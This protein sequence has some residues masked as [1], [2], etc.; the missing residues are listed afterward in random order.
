MATDLLHLPHSCF[1]TRKLPRHSTPRALHGSVMKSKI[2]CSASTQNSQLTTEENRISANYQPNMWNYDLLQSSTSDRQIP[3]FL[4]LCFSHLSVNESSSSS[5]ISFAQALSLCNIFADVFSSF[6]DQN[7]S[8]KASLSEDVKG[9]LSL[10]EASYFAFE[11]ENLLDEAKEFTRMHLKDPKV[12]ISKS[13]A[14]Q[15][16]HALELPLNRR[17]QRLEAR[18][19][20]ESYSRR[21]DVN[22]VVLELAKLDFNR[23]QFEHQKELRDMSRWWRA[24]GLSN[25]L[26]FARDR[27]MES[28][29]W[30]LGM[31]SEP[32]YSNCRKS[33]TKIAKLITILDDV[34]DVYGTLDE[35]EQFTDAVE[36]WDVN[37]VNDLPD[38]MKLCF[39]VLYNSVNEMAYD[40]LK[41][42]GEVFLPYLTKAWADLLK[43]F[44]Q[45]AKWCY[46]KQT[47][48]FVEYLENAWMSISGPLLLVH[49]Y[50]LLGYNIKKEE[51]ECLEKYHNLL[52]WPSVIFRLCNDLASSKAEMERGDT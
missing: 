21:Q 20:I 3:I 32:P 5:D 35:L 44:L 15:V 14:E 50:F 7:G 12:N 1:L 40:I 49:A 34:Y 6:K 4:K 47:P 42:Q 29:F 8:F 24:M 16:N 37:I 41:E 33:L 18:W 46:S 39:L 38:Y 13:L 30:T 23:V 36:R 25:K 22:Q 31:V 2:H 48:K 28:F 43:A 19:T 26:S 52:R 10:Y 27:L 11:G 9:M 17:M 45:E 51:L